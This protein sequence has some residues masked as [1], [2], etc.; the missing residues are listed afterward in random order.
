L[1]DDYINL[2]ITEHIENYVDEFYNEYLR[3]RFPQLTKD[4]LIR[5]YCVNCENT[6]CRTGKDFYDR[7]KCEL[8]GDWLKL[9]INQALLSS[10]I[11][12]VEKA[13]CHKCEYRAWY[14]GPNAY[15][16][17]CCKIVRRT[18]IINGYVFHQHISKVGMWKRPLEYQ[19]EVFAVDR[20]HIRGVVAKTWLP[21][22]SLRE[23]PIET[24][25]ILI[26]QT[27]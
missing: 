15:R 25:K 17:K 6:R 8:C 7:F 12:D 11:D 2:N 14:A 19:T 5:R 22:K 21:Y 10:P 3:E 23:M 26:N 27:S 4:E 20:R 16:N 18:Y 9:R 24:I 13:C 1:I